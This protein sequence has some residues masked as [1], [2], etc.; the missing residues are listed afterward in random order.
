MQTLIFFKAFKIYFAFFCFNYLAVGILVYNMHV[1]A[2][3]AQREQ[4]AMLGSKIFARHHVG[5]EK[6]TSFFCQNIKNV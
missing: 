4:L 3:A 2:K 6:W 5:T 1:V